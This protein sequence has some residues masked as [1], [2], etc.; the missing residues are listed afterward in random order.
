M[1]KIFQSPAKYIQG[2]GVIARLAEYSVEFG[3]RCLVITSS[4]GLERF[5]SVLDENE[6]TAADSVFIREAFG[7]ECCM[8][9]IYR[10]KELSEDEACDVI[11][12]LGGGKV[13]DTA[14]AVAYYADLPVII[15]PTNA[16]S[17]APCSAVSVV[18]REDGSLEVL[19]KLKKN[20][21]LVL[22]D[23]EIIAKAPV[24]LLSA[25]IGDALATYF[26]MKA[27]V[28]T[29]SPNFVGAQVS[30]AA[31]AI[32]ERC[33]ETLM[34][35]GRKAYSAVERGVCTRAV[36]NVIEAN[37]LLSGIGFESGGVCGAHPI[38]VGISA[39]PTVRDNMHGEYVAFGLLVQMILN[40][41]DEELIDDTLEFLHDVDLPVCL[42]DLGIF[43]ITEEQLE[44][45]A[46][47]ANDDPSL[48][49]LPKKAG[50]PEI[51][52]A[53][54][55]ADALGRSYREAWEKE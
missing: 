44:L 27:C 55:A 53:I 18:Y 34:A 48:H 2:K 52:A 43:D 5:K 49:Y 30:L 39:V 25:G 6:K 3:H 46:G 28:E 4:G 19:L 11:I 22:V 9:E 8:A 13:L 45:A 15:A 37:I 40:N 31:Q 47:I 38:N 12:G 23:S 36:E 41:D 20:P 32:A 10:L 26:E 54:L 29:D 24:R 1:D 17:D 16:A 33:Y 21:D 51:K 50:V 14:K 7:G 42:A 35:D